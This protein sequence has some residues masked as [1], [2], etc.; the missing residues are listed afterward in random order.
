M[1]L[2]RTKKY[3]HSFTQ[4]NFTRKPRRYA[5][6]RMYSHPATILILIDTGGGHPL[7]VLRVNDKLKVFFAQN[8]EK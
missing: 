3:V 5:F 2:L 8:E 7:F 1:P 4:L 6:L